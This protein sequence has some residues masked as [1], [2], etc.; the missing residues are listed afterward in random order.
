LKI[1][2]GSEK[3]SRTAQKIFPGRPRNF[4][5][6]PKKFSLAAQEISLGCLSS[7]LGVVVG[8]VGGI[9]NMAQI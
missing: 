2:V 9:K 7:F 1:I 5:Y 4:P 3:F 8:G 6:P